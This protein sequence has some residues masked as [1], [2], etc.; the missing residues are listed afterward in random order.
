MTPEDYRR[1]P[2]RFVRDFIVWDELAAPLLPWQW[3]ALLAYAQA[4]EAN[5]RARMRSDGWV[6]RAGEELARLEREA[7]QELE[8]MGIDWGAGDDRTVHVCACGFS[9]ESLE[10]MAD[11]AIRG[12]RWP[13]GDPVL[14]N[15]GQ[16][17]GH[18]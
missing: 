14:D 10:A 4:R 12:H 5:R 2:V 15:Q 6:K 18:L 7:N 8:G 16:G 3:S 17:D 11:H 1:D 13:V 9:S